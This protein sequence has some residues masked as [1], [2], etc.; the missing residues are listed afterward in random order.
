MHTDTDRAYMAGLIDAD[1]H[2]A[3]P[4]LNTKNGGKRHTLDVRFTNTDIRVV[5]QIAAEWGGGVNHRSRQEEKGWKPTADARWM[6][7]KAAALLRDI[8]PYLRI[9]RERAEIALRFSETLRPRGERGHVLTQSEFDTRETMRLELR[10][11]NQRGGDQPAQRVAITLKPPLTCR[12][13]KKEFTDYVQR[14]MYCSLECQVQAGRDAYVERHS[15]ERTCPICDTRFLAYRDQQYC[16]N[17]CGRQSPAG[18]KQMI[19]A[20]AN[21]STH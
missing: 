20:R 17:R 1:G 14:K 10:A 7:A 11:L 4:L 2:I 21:H 5:E 8:L 13:C 19:E 12:R 9:K 3:M 16:S 15:T 18:R 6:T